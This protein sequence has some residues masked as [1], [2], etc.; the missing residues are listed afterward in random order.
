[1]TSPY[2]TEFDEGS[3]TKGEKAPPLRKDTAPVKSGTP[4]PNW[5]PKLEGPRRTIFKALG[6]KVK[7]RMHEDY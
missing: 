6:R 4:E 7:T 3:A 1:M 5:M 2:H